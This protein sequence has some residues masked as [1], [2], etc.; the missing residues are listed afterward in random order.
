MKNVD[1]LPLEKNDAARETFDASVARHMNAFPCDLDNASA[2]FAGVCVS[3][4]A[5][6]T[7]PVKRPIPLGKRIYILDADQIYAPRQSP[8][9]QTPAHLQAHASRVPPF[10]H[11]LTAHSEI[12][13]NRCHLEQDA[14]KMATRRVRRSTVL[15]N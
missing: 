13:H 6:D 3:A 11:S 14:F 7:L 10:R 9:I 4:P 5:R 8:P 2:S 1:Y 12:K 15:L